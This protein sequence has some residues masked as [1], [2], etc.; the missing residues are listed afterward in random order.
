LISTRSHPPT[1]RRSVCEQAITLYNV[2]ERFTD[3]SRRVLVL[4]QEEAR[5]LGHSFIGTEHLLLGLMAEGQGVA[6][7]ALKNLGVSLAAVRA[8]VAETIGM[9]GSAPSGSPPFTPRAKKVLEL[10][11]RESMQLGRTY[12]DTG[13]LLLGLLREGEGVAVAV[14]VG[15]GVEPGRVRQET[16]MLMTDGTTGGSAPQGYGAAID[17]EWVP[18]LW[19]R[20]SEGTVPAVLPINALLFESD[21]V[22]LAIDHLDVYPNGFTVNFVRRVN[23]RRAR[24]ALAMIGAAGS[25]WIPEVTV[26][27]ADGRT[28]KRGHFVVAKDDDGIP[29]EPIQT[30]T[31]RSGVG[32]PG[33]WRAWAWVFPLPPDGPL[34]IL[35]ALPAIGLSS[36]QSLTLDGSMVRAEAQRAKIIWA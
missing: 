5:V 32:E 27:F 20:P 21:V 12:I 7:Q 16:I 31:S 13:D 17:A 34:E 35:V 4:A 19:D 36:P 28:A 6:S 1:S 11:L 22:A 14:L 26:H 18:P 23:P 25:E 10:S 9:A 30:V 2:F 29:V 33:G 15:L 8:E 24:E 3:R